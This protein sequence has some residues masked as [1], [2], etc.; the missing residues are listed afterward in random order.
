MLFLRQNGHHEVLL[1]VQVRALLLAGLPSSGVE[2]RPQGHMQADPADAEDQEIIVTYDTS[3]I[4]SNRTAATGPESGHRATCEQILSTLFTK[5]INHTPKN[6]CVLT[7]NLPFYG[8]EHEG[9]RLG[10]PTLDVHRCVREIPM[11]LVQQSTTTC[12]L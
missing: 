11:I 8:A 1:A 10:C 7:I 6:P 5:L 3:R 2:E 9:A 12:H 4:N